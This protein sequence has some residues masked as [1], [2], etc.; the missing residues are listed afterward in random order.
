MRVE[1]IK[2]NRRE[3]NGVKEEGKE[4]R[5]EGTSINHKREKIR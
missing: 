2:E 5:E 4:A 1:N 3:E